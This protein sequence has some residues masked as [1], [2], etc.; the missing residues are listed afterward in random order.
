[1]KLVITFQGHR[2]KRE[3]YKL[4]IK[5]MEQLAAVTAS[6]ATKEELDNLRLQAMQLSAIIENEISRRLG[7]H[8]ADAEETI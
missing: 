6:A 7:H 4:T 1:M 8:L 2:T 3:L 5:G